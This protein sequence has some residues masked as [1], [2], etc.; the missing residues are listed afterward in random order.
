MAI[1][2]S[3]CWTDRNPKGPADEPVQL[4]CPDGTTAG[5]TLRT[6]VT[7]WGAY[8]D[9]KREHLDKEILSGL[10]KYY[11]LV[12]HEN[13]KEFIIHL[14]FVLRELIIIYSKTLLRGHKG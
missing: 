10:S 7:G 9:A 3:Y 11:W 1:D 2:E 14:L 13:M 8:L 4:V 5:V 6:T 12:C